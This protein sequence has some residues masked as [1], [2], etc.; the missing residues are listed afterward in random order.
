MIDITNTP[1]GGH[2]IRCGVFA[3][4]TFSQSQ[5]HCGRRENLEGL[6]PYD[7]R[8]R[9]RL[10]G[11]PHLMKHI[12]GWETGECEGPGPIR[13]PSSLDTAKARRL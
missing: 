7:R 11:S 12:R 6:D 4:K 8:S 2:L 5:C 13:L 10:H 1:P 3:C 9:Q